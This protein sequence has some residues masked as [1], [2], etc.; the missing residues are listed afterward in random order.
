MTAGQP[1]GGTPAAGPTEQGLANYVLLGYLMVLFLVFLS[2]F[3]A[4]H[5]VAIVREQTLGAV[6]VA[7]GQAA[8]QVDPKALAQGQA[9][10]QPGPA[11]A[12]F[13]TTL[14]QQADLNLSLAPAAGNQMYAGSVQVNS[15]K[16][17]TSANVGQT[18][19]AE[20]LRVLGP[21]VFAE[22]EAPV[23][24]K[25]AGL[26]VLTWTIRVADLKE[27][28]VYNASTGGWH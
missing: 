7:A 14:E 26:A 11:Q 13:L 9:V 12:A 25:V 20:G 24:V 3:G 6:E 10:I 19:P 8:E 1:L 28:A 17:Y 23:V 18:T 2:I 22:V 15:F 4:L 5:Q 16:V 21:S 27:A